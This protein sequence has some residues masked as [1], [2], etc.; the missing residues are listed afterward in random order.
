VR[1]AA[2]ALEPLAGRDRI[3]LNVQSATAVVEADESELYEAIKNVIENA[4]RYAPGSPVV[5]D[6]ASSDAGVTV[7]VSDRGPGMEPQD[8]Q[9]AFDRFYRG[10][11]RSNTEGSGLGL[12]IAKR[13]IERVGGAIALVSRP[14]EG[15]RV[16]MTVPRL[17][18]PI[19]SGAG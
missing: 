3:V 15:T 1:R 13:A 12:A 2:E 9:H 14:G 8:L 11:S 5:I 6:V 4:V 16:T 7:T 17:P 19:R 18:Q 10:T